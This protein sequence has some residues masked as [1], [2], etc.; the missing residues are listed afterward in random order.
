MTMKKGETEIR[1]LGRMTNLAISCLTREEAVAV[2]ARFLPRL[3]PA[4]TGAVFLRAA[5]EDRYEV[6]TS[7]GEEKGWRSFAGSDCWSLRRRRLHSVRRGKD[8]PVCPHTDH[9]P[10]QWI[11]ICIPMTSREDVLGVFHL[12]IPLAPGAG[13]GDEPSGGVTIRDGAG[14]EGDEEPGAAEEYYA[15]GESG[16][17]GAARRRLATLTADILTMIFIN[18]QLRRKLD[19]LSVRDGMTGCFNRRYLEEAL[20]RELKIARRAGR[21][22]AV[23][24]MDIDHFGQ[25]TDAFG[26]GASSLVLRDLGGFLRENVRE[27]DLACR[28]GADEF[29]LMFPETDLAGGRRRAEHLQAMIRDLSRR[30]GY[31]HLRRITLSMGV[32]ACPDQGETPGDLLEAAKE[33]LK[34]AKQTG[35][36]R[37]C[38]AE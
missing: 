22:L 6:V 24:L 34:K 12:L 13:A 21:P 17:A 3:F 15:D 30:D 16:A 25:F 23:V 8:Q 26:H 2:A 32:A 27:V 38:S 35:R 31:T 36:D 20:T 1:L 33:A 14:P 4:E 18:L 29:A 5:A 28:Y 7:W 9:D 37:I 11:S 19:D 10:E